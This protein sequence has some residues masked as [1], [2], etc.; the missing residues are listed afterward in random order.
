MSMESDE[1]GKGAPGG[2]WCGGK[3]DERRTWQVCACVSRARA[4]RTHGPFARTDHSHARAIH[5]LPSFTPI[6]YSPFSLLVEFSSLLV[7]MWTTL[8]QAQSDSDS[9]DSVEVVPDPDLQVVENAGRQQSPATQDHVAYLKRFHLVQ[10]PFKE[11]VKKNRERDNAMIAY[12]KEEPSLNDPSKTSLRL[13]QR[14]AKQ[15]RQEPDWARK[16][17]CTVCLAEGR[18]MVILSCGCRDTIFHQGCVERWHR[19]QNASCT[20][21]L[22]CPTCRERTKPVNLEWAMK[23]AAE[24]EA[25]LKGDKARKHA[26]T[27]KKRR[28]DPIARAKQQLKHERRSQEV[29]AKREAAG[30]V[31]PGPSWL[32]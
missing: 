6:I 15:D 32:A 30:K 11:G 8:T 21:S 17:R 3:E 13:L 29:R 12:F 7:Q 22:R 25:C 26:A 23:S 31:G 5:R 20:K 16:L 1:A 9:D 10:P 24:Q 18:A 28:T 2:W 27:K 4:I 14:V 19:K